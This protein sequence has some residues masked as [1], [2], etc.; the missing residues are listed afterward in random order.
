MV[1]GMGFYDAVNKLYEDPKNK[2]IRRKSWD[3]GYEVSLHIDFDVKL[4]CINKQN[5]NKLFLTNID[6]SATDWEISR[7]SA[8]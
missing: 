5:G 6:F 8:F 2:V 1:S 4:K 7:A 3:S